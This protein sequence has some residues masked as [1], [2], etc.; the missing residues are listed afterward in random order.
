M[1]E[2]TVAFYVIVLL[3]LGMAGAIGYIIA[4]VHFSLDRLPDTGDYARIRRAIAEATEN[5]KESDRKKIET[6]SAR[7]ASNEGSTSL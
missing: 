5:K 6:I 7:N 4:V 3:V 2:P 1:F